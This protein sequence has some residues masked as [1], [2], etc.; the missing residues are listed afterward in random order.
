VAATIR[1]VAQRAGVSFKTVSRV[2]NDEPSVRPATRERVRAAVRELGY[3][4]HHTARQMRTR[5]SKTIGFVSDEIATSPFAV[6]IIKGAQLAAWEHGMM[7]LVV[8]TERDAEVESAAIASLLERRVEGVVYAAMFHRVVVPLRRLSEVPTVLVD[9][10]DAAG[11]FPAVVPDE[12]Q[13]GYLATRTLIDRGHRRIGFVNLN[14]VASA[15][16]AAGRLAGY[17]R[18]LHDAG[19]AVDDRL[20]VHASTAAD[21]GYRLTSALLDLPDRPTALF[22]GNDRTAAGAYCAIYQRGLRIPEDVAVV[23]F[24][25]QEEIAAHLMPALTSVALPHLAMGR[26]GVERL[27][28]QLAAP[29]RPPAMH[30]VQ[31]LA[32]PLVER[33]S[34]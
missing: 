9:C 7:L 26:W 19:I 14:P 30:V 31:R 34:H 11:A 29:S 20:V 6:D 18:A 8:N 27:V 25:D 2:L 17:R 12:E 16:A 13:G 23:G 24:D 28:E 4:P 33:A 22:C 3:T 1:D 15:A 10:F 5:R 21:Q 32:C